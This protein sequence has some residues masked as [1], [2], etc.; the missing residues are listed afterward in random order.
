[1]LRATVGEHLQS[2]LEWRGERPPLAPSALLLARDLGV[3]GAWPSKN[4]KNLV[5]F[6]FTPNSFPGP[7]SRH[8]RLYNSSTVY[9]DWFWTVAKCSSNSE[10]TAGFPT[11]WN[12][13][14][15]LKHASWFAESVPYQ[16]SVSTGS[17]GTRFKFRFL[18]NSDR[19]FG[20]RHSTKW[21]KFYFITLI[22]LLLFIALILNNNI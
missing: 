15:L 19:A 11:A 3:Q 13:S 2:V 1:M 16:L 8:W 9:N 21:H 22:L 17:I 18:S 10:M 20:R 12:V 14:K 7:P 4:G 6:G 5:L